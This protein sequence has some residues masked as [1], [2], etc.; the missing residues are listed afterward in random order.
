VGAVT[1]LVIA[2]PRSAF[3]ERYGYSSQSARLVDDP[4]ELMSWEGEWRHRD[5]GKHC[6][7]IFL[8][9]FYNHPRYAE[10]AE[11]ARSRGLLPAF[12]TV[13]S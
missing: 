13:A 1:T 11:M 9:Q 2:W 3:F 6:R 7:L 10:L 8:G 12:D 4:R 5:A